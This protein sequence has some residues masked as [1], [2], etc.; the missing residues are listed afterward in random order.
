MEPAQK[1]VTPAQPGTENSRPPKANGFGK[2]LSSV[3]GLQQRLDDCS[4]EDANRAEQKT[5][6]LIQQLK[7]SQAQLTLVEKLRASVA[8]IN[9]F[10]GE[11]PQ[12]DFDLIAPNRLD[13]H[14]KLQA[15]IQAGKLIRM[16]LLLQA[17][18]TGAQ[19]ISS[20]FGAPLQAPP[21]IGPVCDTAGQSCTASVPQPSVGAELRGGEAPAP[22]IRVNNTTPADDVVLAPD[23][24]LAP[25]AGAAPRREA[26]AAPKAEPTGNR[27]ANPNQQKTAPNKNQFDERLLN[28]L[29]DTYGE[30]VV[31]NQ[32]SKPIEPTPKDATAIA[33]QTNSI[34]RLPAIASVALVAVN[35]DAEKPLALPPPE[36]AEDHQTA[37]ETFVPSI[38]NRGELDRQLKS[39]IKDYGENDLYSH[40]K[41]SKF[42]KIAAIAAFIVLGLV[43][44]AFYLFKSP[45]PRMPVAAESLAPA[46]AT[47]DTPTNLKPEVIKEKNP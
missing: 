45:P 15:I 2:V 38:K 22:Q 34:E 6:A 41:P 5:R 43:L 30:F 12:A 11:I 25:E 23:L 14:P 42:N 13:N 17:V 28:D 26:T 3:H 10:V 47:S 44:G 36:I 19:S 39:I 8:D 33:A 9:R 31:S 7:A 16:Y 1:Q 32:P 37:V 24:S 35:N 29:I 20:D 4:L 18:R 40:T 46:Q 27:D 21:S